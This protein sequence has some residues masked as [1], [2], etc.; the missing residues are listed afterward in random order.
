[1]IG[2][3]DLRRALEV[4]LIQTALSDARCVAL[5][6][7]PASAAATLRAENY[8]Q[9]PVV[10]DGRIIGVAR[11]EALASSASVRDAMRV[12][13]DG[14]LISGDTP[15]LEVPSLL[16]A[17]PFLFVVDQ[18]RIAGFVTPWDLNKQPA[19]ADLYF[20]WADLEMSL[21]AVLRRRYGREQR[22]M[23]GLLDDGRA[24]KIRGRFRRARREDRE[25]DVAALLDFQDL[26]D[27]VR[28]D[29]YLRSRLGLASRDEWDVAVSGFGTTREG[30]MHLTGELVGGR[31]RLEELIDI[32]QRARDVAQKA[33]RV[34]RIARY[35]PNQTATKSSQV[36]TAIDIAAG[37]IR[38]PKPAKVLF[39]ARKAKVLI[40]LRGRSLTAGYDPRLGPDRE[41]SAVLHVGRTRLESATKAGDR[42]YLS[43]RGSVV[44]LE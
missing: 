41:R 25:A 29:G 26:L 42:L 36:I 13:S 14:I 19:R 37:R 6:D 4:R 32:E 40:S 17:E 22:A 43:V 7:D 20:L 5:E 18:A 23:L 10:A 11:R 31:L 21:A 38:F 24:S 44:E 2:R 30:V 34:R 1:M 3:G 8:D 9:A 35:R 39:P 28:A 16:A 27:I 15:L 12:L 33:G